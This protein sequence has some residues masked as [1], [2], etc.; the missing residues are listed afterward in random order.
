M[1]GA[2]LAAPGF[3]WSSGRGAPAQAAGELRRVGS[4]RRSTALPLPICFPLL[5]A[6]RCS[7][8]ASIYTP[9]PL[10]PDRFAHLSVTRRLSLRLDITLWVTFSRLYSHTSGL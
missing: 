5:Q 3:I 1:D 6:S 8:P 7:F 4:R 9:W 10:A 2:G